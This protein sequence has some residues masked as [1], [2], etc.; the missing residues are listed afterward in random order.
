MLVV[1]L[2]FGNR[3]FAMLILP[4]IL[5]GY[6]ICN[7][8]T[9]HHVE[10]A[11]AGFGFWGEFNIQFHWSAQVLAMGL[12]FVNAVLINLQFNRNDFME[13]NNFITALLYVT[14]M[15]FQHSFYFLDGLGIAQT[16]LILMLFQLFKLRQNEDGRRAVFN[17]AFLYGLACS[18]FPVLLLGT[19][20][21]FW[22]I[23]VIR[24]FIFRESM[25]IILGFTV[26]LIYSG[27]YGAMFGVELE[28][29]KFSSSSAN[30]HL[31]E[32]L[33]L[34]GGGVLLFFA[35]VN[36]LLNKLRVSS[37]RLKKVFRV[38]F[39]MSLLF[40]ATVVLESFAFNK[41][42]AIGLI[43]FPLCFYLPYA[44]GT[45]ELRS[46]PSFIYYL[47]FFFS[48]GKFFIPFDSLA[49]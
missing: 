49:F 48:V 2:F 13:K 26:P 42:D 6:Y 15:S 22:M 27:I 10:E 23:W 14:L 1:K 18:F 20:V 29:E 12:I 37:I 11:K 33:V 16:L 31:F 19:P 28:S 5:G 30:V 35:S 45:K 46:F 44:F 21:I 4:F 40:V 7:Y 25:L 9:G 8:F 39:L 47:I 36:L 34:I 43:I 32:S 38:L 3:S 24:P 17:T 41:L